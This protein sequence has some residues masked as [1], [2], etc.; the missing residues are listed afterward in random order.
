MY[1]IDNRIQWTNNF[2]QVCFTNM[3]VYFRG[4]TARVLQQL[5]D[6]SQICAI[7]Q[8]EPKFYSDTHFSYSILVLHFNIHV[9][10]YPKF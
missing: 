10:N 9:S 3:G 6:I 7:F 2:G 1:P 5:L 4:S 8:L